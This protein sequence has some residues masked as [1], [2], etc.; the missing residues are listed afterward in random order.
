MREIQ[1][2]AKR[3]DTGEWVLSG[4]LLHFN[5]GNK[6]YIPAKDSRVVARLDEKSNIDM[7][8]EMVFFRVHGET[9]GQYT[10][11][12]DK[13]GTPIF[14]GDILRMDT[15]NPDIC[16]V[17]FIEGAFC[18]QFPGVLYPVDIHYIHHADRPQATIIGTIHDNPE[19]LEVKSCQT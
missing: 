2:R 15:F 8:E 17:R 19:L 13:N 11:M 12:N 4:N 10:G 5:E 3:V 7:L 1:F 18:L 6:F 9:V 16:E 14:E